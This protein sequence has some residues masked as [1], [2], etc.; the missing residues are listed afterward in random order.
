MKKKNLIIYIFFVIVVMLMPSKVMA[1]HPTSGGITCT[2]NIPYRDSA[3][4]KQTAKYQVKVKN[5]QLVEGRENKT[6]RWVDD[7]CK[8]GTCLKNSANGNG[9][10]YINE[11]GLDKIDNFG[12]ED[13]TDWVCPKI[14]TGIYWNSQLMNYEVYINHHTKADEVKEKIM[15]DKNEPFKAFSSGVRGLKSNYQA[16]QSNEGAEAS[17]TCIWEVG[18]NGKTHNI[19]LTVFDDTQTHT[20]KISGFG[21]S[22][23]P[24]FNKYGKTCKDIVDNLSYC[25]MAPG[26]NYDDFIIQE[27]SCQEYLLRLGD[28][29]KLAEYYGQI[30][31]LKTGPSITLDAEGNETVASGSGSTANSVNDQNR[32]TLINL[33]RNPIDTDCEGIL[34][35]TIGIINEVLGWIKILAPILLILFG[36]L[37]FAKAVLANDDAAL[38][39]ASSNF[40]KRAI[41]AVGVFFV[42]FIVN[43][44]LGLDGIKDVL[45][46]ALCEG[47]GKVVIK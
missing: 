6:F 34:G 1:D 44:L 25:V 43:L 23:I 22:T 28:S 10:N 29:A 39:K 36:S 17:R 19:T 11:K 41:A 37:D 8:K 20:I 21:Q 45:G 7:T 27:N 30:N 38:K 33:I 3:N 47:I 16:P 14:S 32:E 5:G 2:Y 26:G 12:S 15:Y 18:I 13:G 46:E 35:D 24:G 4:N 9:S 42:P 40:I 31:D